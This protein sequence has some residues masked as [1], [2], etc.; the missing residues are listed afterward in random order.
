[1]PIP[2]KSISAVSAGVFLPGMRV[3]ALDRKEGRGIVVLPSV[4]TWASRQSDT[5]IYV[6]FDHGG[7]GWVHQDVL[8]HG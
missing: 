3:T 5:V 7:C 8:K 6:R 1:M 4:E 2:G